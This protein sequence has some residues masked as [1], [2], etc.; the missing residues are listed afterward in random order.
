MRRVIDS[1]EKTVRQ[2]DR[3]FDLLERQLAGLRSD[4]GGMQEMYVDH[5]EDFRGLSERVERIER[6][7]DLSTTLSEH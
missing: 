4:I 5:R 6:H 7:L 1:I 2:H 3:R